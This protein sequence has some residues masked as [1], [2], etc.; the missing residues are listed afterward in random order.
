MKE[1]KRFLALE[2][3]AGSGKTSSLAVRFV[4]LILDK[5]NG[6]YPIISSYNLYKQ[7][8]KRDERKNHQ[9]IFKSAKLRA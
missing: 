7:S 1:D 9:N 6:R 5:Q 2:A 4:A 8:R 3:S